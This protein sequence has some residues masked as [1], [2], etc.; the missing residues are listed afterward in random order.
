MS[1]ANRLPTGGRIDRDKP[2]FFRF[3]GKSYTGYSGDTLASALLASD[4]HL[5]GRSIK[6]HRPRGIM[7]AG[8]EEPNGL[9]QLSEGPH[10]EPN[11]CATQIEIYEGLIAASQNCWPSVAFDLGAI[12]S[13]LSRLIPA[14]F[15]YKTFMWPASMWMTYE[16]CIRKMAGLGKSPTERDP[17]RYENRYAHCDVLVV[18]GGPAGLAAALAAGSTGARVILADEQS[19]FGGY[20]LGDGSASHIAGRLAAD[21]VA[22]ALQE[23]KALPEVTLLPRTTVSG[24]Y[25]YNFLTALERVTD[26]LPL[27]S[28][29]HLPRQR[30]WKIRARQVVLATGAI[31][32]PLVFADNDRPGVMLAWAVRT[33]INRYGVLPGKRIVV[34]TNNDS[35]YKTA[36]RAKSVG[37]EVSV[38]DLRPAPN[39]PWVEE[40]RQAGISVRLNEAI[41][42][43]RGKA[44][45]AG[46]EVMQLSGDGKGVQGSAER[47]ACSLV[48]VS[49][50]W[51]P[52]VHLHSQARGKLEYD[53]AIAAF[54]PGAMMAINPHFCAGACTGHWALG[55]CIAQGL[56][57]G[58]AAAERA[59]FGGGPAPEPPQVDERREESM[60]VLWTVPC[61]HPLGQGPK[62]HFHDFQ[63]DVTAA[64]IHLAAREGYLS[65]E[66]LKR[67]TTTGMGTDQGK[68]SNLN[69]LAILSEIRGA[70]IPEVGTTTFRPPYTPITF[71]A[72]VGLERGELFEQK[73]KTP[74]HWWHERNGAVF[75]CVGDWL[76]A[77][78]YPRAGEGMH[79]AVQRECKAVRTSVGVVDVS[80][81]G[82]I[83]IQGPD[84]ADFLNMIYTNAWSKLGIGRCRYGL[85]L[86]EH[87]MIFDDGVTTRLG[88]N[89]FHMTT[90][91]GGAAR[92]MIWIE[93]WLQTEW[94]EM[95]VYCTNVTE[96][97]AV[98]ALNGP[99]SRE[100]LAELTDMDLDPEAFPFLSMKEGTVAGVPAR[101]YRISFSGEIAYEINVP[102]RY[103][104]HLWEGLIERGRKYDLCPYGTEALHMLRAEKGFVIIGK[105]TDGTLTPMDLGMNWI[106]SK[107]KGDFIGRR[108]FARPD[109]RRPGRRQ[110]VG[111]LTED[112]NF[113]LP[114]GVHL[115]AKARPKPPMQ[116]VGHVTS[117]Y[118]SPN[119]GCSIALALV[120]DGRARMG[121]T[122]KAYTIEGRVEPVTIT[123]PVFF[124][125]EGV[126]ARA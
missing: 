42:G 77:W 114:E 111:L 57:A 32:Q 120:K 70:E 88:E 105:D 6:Y 19:E 18:G 84:A 93:E 54:V 76:R 3:N 73:R 112:P 64:D 11:T 48:A 123:E 80:T 43:V 67:Y 34:F 106:V 66:H 40:A 38:V 23:L 58:A 50:G 59:G 2:I 102:A 91:T 31:E 37:A 90:T 45:V 61:E 26:L 15:Y 24:Y 27:G 55:D 36:L 99:K 20:L 94:P 86:N 79:E 103:G 121:Q 21:W 53:E 119:V 10:T 63:N 85:M 12:N 108:S 126:R 83:D 7:T 74:M 92:V 14:G 28:G 65:V 100:L 9:V 69:A 17:D 46:V 22:D 8:S 25:D 29:G 107:N 82:K 117:S 13:V 60:R 39:G 47:I 78:H 72:V 81:L 33:Y 97:W 87:G 125:K 104:L 110:L 124:D 52:T 5:I 115:V 4:V 113:L 16:H 62:M 1:Q 75:E 116:T 56:G 35:A 51:T 44:R 68:T 122:L 30:F 96:Q 49:G 118:M 109:T 71:G 89:H 101:I 95:R 98:A 41:T